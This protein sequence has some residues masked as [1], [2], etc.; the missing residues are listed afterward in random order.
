MSRSRMKSAANETV[1][2]QRDDVAR[3]ARQIDNGICSLLR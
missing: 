3:S 1:D 2:L